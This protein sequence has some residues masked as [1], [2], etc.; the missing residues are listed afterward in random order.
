VPPFMPNNLTIEGPGQ[1]PDIQPE[2]FGL[3][4]G[5]AD[6][7]DRSDAAGNGVVSLAATYAWRTLKDAHFER[8]LN[9]V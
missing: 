1:R 3:D 8:T 7:V 9:R 4:H 2:L 5:M 6:R